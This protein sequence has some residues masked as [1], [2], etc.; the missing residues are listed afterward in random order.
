MAG[1]RW[2]SGGLDGFLQA[3]LVGMEPGYPT[4]NRRNARYR[5]SVEQQVTGC[6]DLPQPSPAANPSTL[7]FHVHNNGRAG[8]SYLYP[9]RLTL[10]FLSGNLI[11]NLAHRHVTYLID[12][13]HYRAKLNGGRCYCTWLGT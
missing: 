7:E 9:P 11:L 12:G 1:G 8:S 5:G 13:R 10:L 3:M 6:C 2:S 4:V